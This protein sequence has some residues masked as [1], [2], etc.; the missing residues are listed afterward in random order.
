[1]ASDG[2]QGQLELLETS[3]KSRPRRTYSHKGR[4]SWAV[5]LPA[6]KPSSSSVSCR[7]NAQ[8]HADSAASLVTSP[9][10]P[11]SHSQ[12][13]PA[14][15]ESDVSDAEE[16][17]DDDFLILSGQAFA[18][19]TKHDR[20]TGN[21]MRSLRRRPFL[22]FDKTES[23][24][25][26]QLKNEPRPAKTPP[27]SRYQPGDGFSGREAKPNGSTLLVRTG[28]LSIARPH[29]GILDLTQSEPALTKKKRNI[30][31]ANLDDN[32]F[33]AAPKKKTRRP[34]QPKDPNQPLK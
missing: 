15:E 20:R 11:A 4:T 25:Y 26:K 33:M 22:I 29:V 7:S 27:V 9:V 2:N 30:R 3:T 23:K 6:L 32:S 8:M 14:S 13:S 34:L 1:M 28:K 5:S 18:N 19:N 24:G 17:E 21:G 16:D 31:K 12:T 10:T